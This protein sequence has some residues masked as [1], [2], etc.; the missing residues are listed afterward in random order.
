MKVFSQSDEQGFVQVWH[1]MNVQPEQKPIEKL[2]MKIRTKSQI[3]NVQPGTKA[4]QRTDADD[5]NVQPHLHKT[6]CCLQPYV[7]RL[8]LHY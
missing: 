7:R 1:S 5:Y 2:M 6:P 4:Q 8:T 3:T